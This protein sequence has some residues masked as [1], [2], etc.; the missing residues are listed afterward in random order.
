[1]QDLR[2]M[3]ETE[4]LN[5]KKTTEKRS[6]KI[7]TYK[8]NNKLEENQMCNTCIHK[9]VCK[10]K[11]STERAKESMEKT[12][13]IYRIPSGVKIICKHEEEEF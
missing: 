9:N 4:G 10:Y 13:E 3:T 7:I 8:Y 5:K 1:M 2:L 6:K 11:E 12:I